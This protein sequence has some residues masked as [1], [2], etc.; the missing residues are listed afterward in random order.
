MV[1]NTRIGYQTDWFPNSSHSVLGNGTL[2]L[3][4]LAMSRI[5]ILGTRCRYQELSFVAHD[6]VLGTKN[7]VFATRYLLDSGTPSSC[8]QIHGVCAKN[9]PGPTL[10]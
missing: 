6:P 2:M 5:L 3:L 4:I 1:P 9:E 10:T 7:L 8:F